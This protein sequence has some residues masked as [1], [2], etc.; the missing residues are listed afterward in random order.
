MDN[1]TS[2]SPTPEAYQAACDALWA[3]RD[4]ANAYEAGLDAIRAWR[5]SMPTGGTGEFAGLD[6]ILD[7]LAGDAASAVRRLQ[8]PTSLQQA[9][10]VHREVMRERRV[11]L[12]AVRAVWDHIEAAAIREI[13]RHMPHSKA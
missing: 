5:H 7:S 11:A 10:T 13:D 3:H 12:A 9:V 6:A 4:R 8:R 1:T 2:T